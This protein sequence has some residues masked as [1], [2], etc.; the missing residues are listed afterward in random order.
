MPA[1]ASKVPLDIICH[2]TSNI[3]YSTVRLEVA[4]KV[5]SSKSHGKVQGVLMHI[6]H[7]SLVLCFP[8]RNFSVFRLCHC[9]RLVV[10]LGVRAGCNLTV[11]VFI[12][13]RGPRRRRRQSG[14]AGVS[15]ATGLT[16]GLEAIGRKTS[17]SH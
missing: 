12:H 17:S 3:Y 7:L 1:L 10:K 5:A 16:L 8:L 15:C 6:H 14:L 9:H 13:Y 4:H 11:C 2:C